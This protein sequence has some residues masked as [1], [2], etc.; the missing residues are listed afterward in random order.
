M[1]LR[2]DQLGSRREA[3][4]RL[5]KLP[6]HRAASLQAVFESGDESTRKIADVT[7]R[8]RACFGVN[9]VSS[10]LNH[11]KGVLVSMTGLKL[12][13]QIA[14]GEC[15]RIVQNPHARLQLLCPFRANV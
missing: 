15:H 3:C 5:P 1:C 9:F 7:E 11:Q 10:L 2:R 8:F 14:E 13:L 6:A 12:H 4:T